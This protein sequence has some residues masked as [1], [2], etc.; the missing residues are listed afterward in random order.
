M[1]SIVFCE[2]YYNEGFK[3]EY[4]NILPHLFAA[5]SL[6]EV[7]LNKLEDKTAEISIADLS[8]IEGV[9]S[10]QKKLLQAANNLQLSIAK[11]DVVESGRLISVFYGL[12]YIVRPS[13][14][15]LIEEYSNSL[16]CAILTKAISEDQVTRH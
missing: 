9:K 14:T 1:F 7:Q 2:N 10:A 13:I 4:A 11:K 5:C 8:E 15:R 12:L 6:I 3:M 16:P